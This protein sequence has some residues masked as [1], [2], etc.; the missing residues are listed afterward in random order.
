MLRPAPRPLA[1]EE[2]EA[3]AID[4]LTYLAGDAELLSRFLALSGLDI[5]SLREAAAEPGFLAGVLAFIAGHERTLTEFA[6]AT[7]QSPESV[8]SANRTL[9]PDACG[10]FS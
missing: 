8:A 4:A 1:R 6:A 7:N 5:A 2:A 3:I 10:D 9:N